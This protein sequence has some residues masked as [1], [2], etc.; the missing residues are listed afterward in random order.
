MRHK[1]TRSCRH[2]FTSCGTVQS[3]TLSN[4]ESR[5]INS[6]VCKCLHPSRQQLTW[7]EGDTLSFTITC[8]C[9]HIHLHVLRTEISPHCASKDFILCFQYD[10][11]STSCASSSISIA[12]ALKRPGALFPPIQAPYYMSEPLSL[13]S[14]SPCLNWGCRCG[15]VGDHHITIWRLEQTLSSIFFCPSSVSCVNIA[16]LLPA[17]L[18]MLM[19]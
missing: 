9:T 19:E 4:K 17:C 16:L 1:D 3:T 12:V 13:L 15:H 2:S 18:I 7:A 5:P 6:V 8:T 14:S 11:Q 10:W